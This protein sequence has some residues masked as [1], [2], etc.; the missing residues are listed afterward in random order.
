MPPPAFTLWFRGRSR[1]GIFEGS[2]PLNSSVRHTFST[3]T[4]SMKES[5]VSFSSLYVRDRSTVFRASTRIN[6]IRNDNR[7]TESKERAPPNEI[8]EVQRRWKKKTRKERKFERPKGLR[9]S[10]RSSEGDSAWNVLDA[11]LP[12]PTNK[13]KTFSPARHWRQ[14]AITRPRA[15][16]FMDYPL[17]AV[18]ILESVKSQTTN[19]FV[20]WWTV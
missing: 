19:V 12:G 1:Q 11:W 3:T 7:Q 4:S 14:A 15:N 8:K 13:I 6:H 9:A 17:E 5:S 20:R 18:S 10:K 16:S 2:I